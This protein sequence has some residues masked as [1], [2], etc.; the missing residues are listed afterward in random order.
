MPT[1]SGTPLTGSPPTATL[2]P[3]AGR[4]PPPGFENVG[5]PPPPRPPP[6]APPPGAPTPATTLRIVDFPQPLG[7]TSA[8]NSPSPTDNVAPSTASVCCR[9]DEYTIRRSRIVTA[10]V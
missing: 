9:C 3:L 5:V 10:S 1:P 7:P 8:T 6:P 2:P 4:R